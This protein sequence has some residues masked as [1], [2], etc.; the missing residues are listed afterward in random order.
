MNPAEPEGWLQTVNFMVRGATILF[1]VTAWRRVVMGGRRGGVGYPAL[2]AV[3]GSSFIAVACVPQDPAPG[4]DP[5]R[6]TSRSPR[7]PG[8]STWPSPALPQ[9]APL[10]SCS[11]WHPA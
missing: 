1:T 2:T 6:R 11:S 5:A 8:C 7:W 10:P 9:H 4:Y 3:L